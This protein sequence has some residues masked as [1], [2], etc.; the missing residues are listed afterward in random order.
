MY[1]LNKAGELAAEILAAM[2]GY[3]E[4]ST[5]QPFIS[6]IQGMVKELPIATYYVP[7]ILQVLDYAWDD[8]VAELASFANRPS[9]DAL[10]TIMGKTKDLMEVLRAGL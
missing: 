9:E 4:N 8:V 7:I 5:E 6:L 10:D 1:D 2:E 3:T